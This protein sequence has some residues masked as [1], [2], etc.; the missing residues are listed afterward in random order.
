MYGSTVTTSEAPA[1]RTASWSWKSSMWASLSVVAA[2][3]TARSPE[4]PGAA[5]RSS[6]SGKER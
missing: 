3:T 5:A 6:P 2:T 4:K 1:S